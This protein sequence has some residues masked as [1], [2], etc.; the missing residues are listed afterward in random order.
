MPLTK[1][2]SKQLLPVYDK[3]LI[4]Y[5]LST[6]MLAGIKDILII[7]SPRDQDA[8]RALLGDG[9]QWGIS[10]DYAVQVEPK[11]IAEAFLIGADFIS[12][13]SVSLI[14]GDNIF[15]AEG[16][17]DLFQG[18]AQR[19]GLAT[20]LGYYVDD[21][22]RYGVVTFD[23]DGK[24]LSIDE[25]PENPLSHYA[26]TGL[27]FYDEDV[28]EIAKELRPSS[29]GELE[30]TDINRTYLERDKLVVEILGRGTAWLD[31]GTYDSLLDAANFV[32]LIEK[33]QGLKIACPE[34]AAYRMNFIGA[35]DLDRLAESF[36]SSGYGQYLRQLLNESR[37]ER[38]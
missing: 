14:L 10:L 24:A 27:Y 11:G 38:K 5:P 3:P 32:R 28:V 30:I 31:T 8:F 23:H 33:R 35:A 19:E 21:P 1:S 29:R 9:S 36:G 26:V 34:E 22:Q 18:I 2:I 4:H 25:K 13:H 12:G 20:I 6:L 37:V 17:A 15:Y 7:T 16:L